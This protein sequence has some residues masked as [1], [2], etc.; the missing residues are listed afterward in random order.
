MLN[1]RD[2]IIYSPTK[3]DLCRIGPLKNKLKISGDKIFATRQGEG[4]TP[5]E[6]GSVGMQVIFLRLHCCN[7]ACGL[8][9]GWKCDT[10]YTWDKSRSEYWKEP[11]DWG[12]EHTVAEIKKAWSKSFA[13]NANK[14]LVITGGEPLLQQ[15]K[16]VELLKLI[17]D[18]KIEI[19][20]NGTILPRVE[21]SL[22]QFNCSPKLE[23]SGNDL[24]LR[25]K[26]NVL[27]HIG[28]LKNSWF[29]FVVVNNEDL[30]EIRSIVEECQLP[31]Q[32]VLIMPEGH[33]VSDVELHKLN[34]HRAVEEEGWRIAIRNQL[35]WY[36]T[37]RRT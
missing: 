18:W 23:N 19:E 34:I 6:G 21:L 25:Y 16:I 5:E 10:G 3:A 22:C 24:R 29:K 4:L 35:I 9:D 17:P 20:T 31:K 37:K 12:Y 14:R 7:L 11:V 36:G 13:D 28:S 27:K 33:T 30:A 8:E 26:P 15:D 32:K 2:S 1:K